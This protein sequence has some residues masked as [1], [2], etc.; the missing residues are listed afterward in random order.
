MTYI[1]NREPKGRQRG[2]KKHA[3]TN[4]DNKR[5][6]GPGGSL[7]SD[8]DTDAVWQQRVYVIGQESTQGRSEV[9]KLESVSQPRDTH[10]VFLPACYSPG[11]LQLI[12]ILPIN[13][14]AQPIYHFFL[15]MWVMNHIAGCSQKPSS[16]ARLGLT[17]NFAHRPLCYSLLFTL[18]WPSTHTLPTSSPF[19]IFKKRWC[20]LNWRIRTWDR[21]WG[22]KG[23]QPQKLRALNQ[24]I[25]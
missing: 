2:L 25:V 8:G 13:L 17:G 4:R 11:W 20:A 10:C 1:G 6:L 21:T 12:N 3:D 23:L 18:P 24:A 22:A 16:F 15:S 5:K 14:E 9:Q 19:L 7:S